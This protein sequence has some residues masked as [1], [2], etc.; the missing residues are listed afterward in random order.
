M[1]THSHTV[2]RVRGDTH[3]V[4]E[5]QR[6]SCNNT[7]RTHAQQGAGSVRALIHSV[8]LLLFYVKI[9]GGFNK[10]ASPVNTLA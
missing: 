2:G 7:T 4:S 3:T 10:A 8:V 5:F 6:W 9:L 1:G